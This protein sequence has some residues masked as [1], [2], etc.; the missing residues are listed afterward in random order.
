MTKR[1]DLSDEK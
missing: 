1:T